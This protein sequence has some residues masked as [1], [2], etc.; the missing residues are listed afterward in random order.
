M[1]GINLKLTVNKKFGYG[2]Q[3]V[4]L[5]GMLAFYDIFLMV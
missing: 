3:I 4:Q 5:I 1:D 2:G